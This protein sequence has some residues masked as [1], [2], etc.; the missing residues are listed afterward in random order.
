MSLSRRIR[1]V[2]QGLLVTAWWCGALFGSA[3]LLKWNR[4]WICTVLYLGSTI[5]SGVLVT[6]LNPGL[7]K[8]REIA[9]HR[10]TKPFDRVF[11]SLFV[12]LV[13]LLPAIAGLDAVRFGWNPMPFWTLYPGVCLFVASSILIIWVMTRNP[14]AETS[15]RIQTERGHSVVATGPYAFVRHP[16]YVGLILLYISQALILGSMWALILAELIAGLFMWRTA[17]EDRTLRRELSGYEQYT[18]I[19]RYRLIPGVW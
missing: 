12:P 10:D 14:H 9:I 6:K 2:G 7:L 19:T 4:G 18:S 8:E 1:V 16:M 15:V 5:A 3:G 13:I 17:M 11:F